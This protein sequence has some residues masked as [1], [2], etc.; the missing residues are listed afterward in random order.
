MSWN[1]QIVFLC[2]VRSG[3]G[4]FCLIQQLFD[5]PDDLL[6]RLNQPVGS[7]KFQDHVEGPLQTICATNPS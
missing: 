6:V 1:E 5:C 2:T 4:P 7:V 3:A